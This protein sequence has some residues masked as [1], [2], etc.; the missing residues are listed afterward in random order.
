MMHIWREENRESTNAARVQVIWRQKRS[1][2][3]LARN[4][5]GAASSQPLREG[6][7]RFLG[8]ARERLC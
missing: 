1:L 7:V 6:E 3:T 2:Y 4:S 5:E 8:I